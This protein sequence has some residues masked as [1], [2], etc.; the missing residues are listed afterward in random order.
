MTERR[1]R[2]KGE[3]KGLPPL[4][5]EAAAALKAQV[6]QIAAAL[7]SGQDLE[8]LKR[9]VAP[10]PQDLFWDLHLLAALGTLAH[11]HLPGLLAAL[12]GAAQDKTRR[13][14]LKRTLH[15]LKTRGVSVPEELIPREEAPL[16]PLAAGAPVTVYVSPIFGNGERYVILE[17][18]KENLG[19]NFLVVRLSD[20]QGLQE[21]HLL[22]LKRQQRQELWDH[23]RNQGLGEWLTPPAAY[24]L[25]LLK[26]AYETDPSGAPGASRYL[27][28]RE[29]ISAHWGRP[30][31]GPEVEQFLPPLNP[32][33]LSRLL[34]QSRQLAL[35]PLFLSW[36]P[37]MEEITLWLDKIKEVQDSP[38][39]LSEQQQ[40]VRLD[41]VVEEATRALYPQDTRPFWQ[42]RLL[43]MAY[44]LE[45]KSRAEEARVAQA[46]A[47]DLG[48]TDPGPLSGANPFL[49]AL[50]LHALMLAWEF[51]KQ[52]QEPQ[53]AS[54]LLA[55]ANESL[56]IR[57]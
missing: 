8:T 53:A 54:G 33:E 10:Q 48:L 18:P 29:K 3:P 13:K 16:R 30:E 26:E 45:L 19:G 37:S 55:P 17:G 14:A 57:R 4:S 11:P 2:L 27:S 40:Q 56:I 6:A 9:L 41:G 34:E 23:F 44:Y 28:L 47:A 39:V 5:P 50:V 35:D 46:A 52:G 31:E 43:H 20:E 12:F 42:G 21:C 51:Q 24:A 32:G 22:N 1:K 15:L 36:L 25:R 49:K 7:E 38:L